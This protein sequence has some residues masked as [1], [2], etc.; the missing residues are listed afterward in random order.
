MGIGTALENMWVAGQALGLS[1]AFLG[2]VVIAEEAIKSELGIAGDLIGML[3]LGYTDAA[4]MPPP[5][6][7]DS[8][9]PERVVWVPARR[10]VD[11]R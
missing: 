2:D 4:S 10:D 8:H 1:V 11:G 6:E 7:H 5:R 9:D 3:T